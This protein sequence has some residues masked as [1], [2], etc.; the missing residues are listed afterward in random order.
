[1]QFL[2]WAWF[3]PVRFKSEPVEQSI[4]VIIIVVVQM[5]EGRQVKSWISRCFQSFFFRIFFSPFHCFI[6]GSPYV[7]KK[8]KRMRKKNKRDFLWEPFMFHLLML[9]LGFFSESVCAI[10]GAVFL[11]SERRDFR[12]H[13]GICKFRLNRMAKFAVHMR[14]FRSLEIEP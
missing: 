5:T 7:M 2:V 13:S 4:Q 11:F 9:R 1:M 6:W 10:A 12:M 14:P 8:S 3:K